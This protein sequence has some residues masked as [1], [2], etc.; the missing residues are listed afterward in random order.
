MKNTITI[1]ITLAALLFASFCT[2][3][4]SLERKRDPN[5]KPGPEVL[6]SYAGIYSSYELE[7]FYTLEL[8]DSAL[9][10]LLLNGEVS[11]L[12]ALNVDL[13]K[14]NINNVTEM[15]FTRNGAGNVSGFVVSNKHTKGIRFV[16][17]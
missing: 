10:V 1:P 17:D 3:E 13:F 8:R 9:V 15:K 14:C 5:Y 12:D 4:G 2:V 16:K 7:T 11:T 6:Q